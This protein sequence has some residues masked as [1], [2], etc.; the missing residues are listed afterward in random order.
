MLESCH[1]FPS[2]TAAIDHEVCNLKV[3][4]IR[5]L[6]TRCSALF[7][8]VSALSTGDRLVLI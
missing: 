1:H 6:S 7:A 5:V 4:E 2:S 3:C 8:E